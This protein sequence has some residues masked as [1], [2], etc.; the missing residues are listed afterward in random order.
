MDNP[1]VYGPHSFILNFGEAARRGII[2]HYKV[3]VSRITSEDVDNELLNRGE[4][5]V[6]GEAV[7]A[8]TVANQIAMRD[9][10]EKYA[11]KKAFTFHKTVSSAKA[12]TGSG[13]ESI[14]NHLK[15]FD[16]FHING[17]MPTAQ[18]ESVMK[19]FKGSQKA[20]ISNARCLTEGVDV[21]AV[22]MVAFLSPRKS[23]VDIVQ[24]TGRAMRNAPNKTCGYILVPIYVEQEAE[25]TIEAAVAR[26]KYDEV[27]DVLQSMQEQDETLY[28]IIQ[29]MAI[30]K[31][32]GVD[33]SQ[34]NLA[35]KVEV[36]CPE[37][38]VQQ[39]EDS[40]TTRLL[41]K[42]YEGWSI[43]YGQ[44]KTFHDTHGHCN[45]PHDSEEYPGLY[46]WT[47]DHRRRRNQG[48]I[49]PEIEAALDE[50]GFE[51]EKS[52]IHN[53]ERIKQLRAFKEKHGH[54]NV[55]KSPKEDQTVKFGLC[56]WISKHRAAKRKGNINC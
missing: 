32:R 5:L 25:E 52:S 27:W 22:D 21:P 11:P 38:S 28:D 50:M 19:E 13:P 6:K 29:Q 26:A 43:K 10:I 45:V 1:D 56:S 40:I 39:L 46:K 41:D 23:R 49:N 16:T 53:Q 3:I 30:K 20:I 18:R 51:W 8:R 33:D 35:E 36:V 24:A 31:G 2:C 15:D 12:F 7:R 47:V 44:L 54:F 37:L 17:R 14:S 34:A 4:V 48:K 55:P 42:F 9:V